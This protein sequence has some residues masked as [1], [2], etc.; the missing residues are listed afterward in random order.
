MIAKIINTVVVKVL[1]ALLSIFL[2]LLN[3]NYLGAVGLGTIALI[4][5]E[6]AIYLLISNLVTGGS[7]VYYASRIETTELFII[8]YSWMAT[9]TLLLYFTLSYFPFL[10]IEYLDHI[11]LLGLIQSGVSTHINLL[12]GKQQIKPFN[13]TSLIQGLVQ[14][15]S[16]SY[17]YFIL[18]EKT[19]ISFIYST[20]IAYT[21]AYIY[22]LLKLLSY[23]KF[24]VLLP[25]KNTFS[26]V[27]QYGFFI[28]T[29]NISQLLNYRLS[30]FLLEY[31]SGRSAIGQFTAGVQ[32]SEGILLPSKS[33]GIVQYSRLSNTKSILKSAG[34]TLTLLK[35]SFI[36]TLPFLLILIAIPNYL[37][38][39]LLG[40]DF[41]MT[42]VV[43]GLMSVGIIMLASEVIL[44]RFFSG[45]GHQKVNAS[46]STL[47]LIATL[48]FGF[49]LIPTFGFKG[50][51]ITYSLSF[52]AMFIYMLFK[53]KQITGIRYQRFLISTSDLQLIYRVARRFGRR[54]RN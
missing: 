45:S 19:V 30:Y 46:S 33:I 2:L 24:K 5:L 3:S 4:V 41:G 40:E 48:I 44:S 49:L 1:L 37:F 34:L 10:S 35:L 15:L 26:A 32:L 51:A 7:L 54:V 21:A 43:I 28:Q 31:Y 14:V 47:G 38:V 36:I 9:I 23:L 25:K 12:A 50:A 27:I 8:S 42:S 39:A 6:I 18:K 53:F 20:Y 17:F 29:A 52:S 13:F 16:L 22:S 11:L